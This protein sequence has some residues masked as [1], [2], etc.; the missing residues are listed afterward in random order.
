MHH[1]IQAPSLDM[2][3]QFYIQEIPFCANLSHAWAHAND[4][5]ILYIALCMKVLNWNILH[6]NMYLVQR[7]L[8]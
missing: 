4:V 2:F 8:Q 1:D 6:Y 7:I 3:R 5:L